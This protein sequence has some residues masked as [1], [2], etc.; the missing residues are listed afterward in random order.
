MDCQV[1]G[2]ENIDKVRGKSRAGHLVSLV[3]HEEFM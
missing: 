3:H 1:G 2:I